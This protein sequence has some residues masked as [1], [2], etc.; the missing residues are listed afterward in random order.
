LV[1]LALGNQSPR[2][3]GHYFPPLSRVSIPSYLS[4]GGPTERRV[5]PSVSLNQA[6]LQQLDA[7]STFRVYGHTLDDEERTESQWV[8]I[9]PCFCVHDSPESPCP[10]THEFIWWLPMNA[11][12]GRGSAGR[13]GHEGEELQ[14]FDVLVESAIMV[15]SVQPVKAGALKALGDPLSPGTVRDIATGDSAAGVAK[16]TITISIG[17]VKVSIE[18]DVDVD[19]IK[20]VLE[21]ID[22]QGAAEKWKEGQQ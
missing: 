19:D 10:C 12:V 4:V 21:A 6:K 18:F 1:L 22:W 2:E 15:E 16:K 8:P 9:G 14:Y 20:A 17:P 11:I 13:K 7:V 5:V 3:V